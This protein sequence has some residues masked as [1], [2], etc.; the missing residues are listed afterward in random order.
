MQRQYFSRLLQL[1]DGCLSGPHGAAMLA[2]LKPNTLR[3]KLDKLNIPYGHQ[4]HQAYLASA[5]NGTDDGRKEDS[6][7]EVPGSLPESL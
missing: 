3:S 7:P 6:M 1:C 4:R 2:G 5:E